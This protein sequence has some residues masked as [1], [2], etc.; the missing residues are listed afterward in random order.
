MNLTNLAL[1]IRSGKVEYLKFFESKIT[2][3]VDGEEITIYTLEPLF[4]EFLNRAGITLPIYSYLYKNNLFKHI[5]FPPLTVMIEKYLKSIICFGSF[6]Q[7]LTDYYNRCV[8]EKN[9]TL[10]CSP[11]RGGGFMVIMRK[12]GEGK[13]RIFVKVLADNKKIKV[14]LAID[15]TEKIGYNEMSL[16]ISAMDHEHMELFFDNFHDH[17]QE[18]ISGFDDSELTLIHPSINEVE[19]LAEYLDDEEWTRVLGHFSVSRV[20]ELRKVPWHKKEEVVFGVNVK[21]LLSRI[22]V[23]SEKEYDLRYGMY[24]YYLK[25]KFKKNRPSE[26]MII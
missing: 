4:K 8:E 11:S 5:D 22:K 20:E 24:V 21:T 26:T 14:N 6:P 15:N 17:Y 16:D 19:N 7:A 13:D 25:G 9:G 23:F 2:F 12:Q 1:A 10:S 18:V 3:Q